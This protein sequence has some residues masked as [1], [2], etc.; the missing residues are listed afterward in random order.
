LYRYVQ[1]V[2][3]MTICYY[4]KLINY[5]KYLLIQPCGMWTLACPLG[6]Q[7]ICK[8]CGQFC[9][10]I[11]HPHQAKVSCWS[12]VYREITISNGSDY[13]GM[14]KLGN[15]KTWDIVIWIF[16]YPNDKMGNFFNKN[17]IPFWILELVFWSLKCHQNILIYCSWPNPFIHTA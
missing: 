7:T 17:Y 3:V 9:T 16:T 8:I 10:T 15:I 1:Y 14:A 4:F 11:I 6:T 5:A 13:Y 2:Q 12:K